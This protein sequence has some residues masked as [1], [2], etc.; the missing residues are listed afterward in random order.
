MKTLEDKEKEFKEYVTEQLRLTLVI[1][2][3]TINVLRNVAH[4][5]IQ[6]MKEELDGFNSVMEDELSRVKE[7]LDKYK[8]ALD[9][10]Y[11]AIHGD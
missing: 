4:N 1:G 5:I 2:T 6:D 9:V 3:P 8:D 10:Y 7:E 11:K